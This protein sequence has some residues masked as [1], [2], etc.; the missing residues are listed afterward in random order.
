MGILGR[1]NR[2]IKSN[3]NELLDKMTDPAKEVEYLIV[4]MEQGLQQAKEEV[5]SAT[6]D[7]KRAEKHVGECGREA[8][9][10]QQRAEQAVRAG[11]DALAR[12]ALARKMTADQDLEQA[13]T[14]A[15]QQASYVDELKSSLKQLEAR[16]KDVQ[17][18]KE[19]LKQRAKAAKQGHAGGLSGGEAFSKFD[20]L[21]G[22]IEAMEEMQEITA[23]MDGRDAATE[24]RFRALEGDAD[25][26]PKI[27]DELAAL[28]AK[29]D[30][31]SRLTE[32]SGSGES[33]A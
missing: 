30:G 7:S 11:D 14:L 17:A 15:A 6:A 1:I 27:E 32:G 23:S 26:N 8:E 25:R 5:V 19:T 18:R 22:R 31:G 28:K 21:E 10:W 24:A 9:R 20:A 16:L 2:V 29:M 3:M 13:R 12:E 4:E 33:G